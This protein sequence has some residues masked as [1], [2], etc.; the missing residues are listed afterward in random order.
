[1]AMEKF[2][3]TGSVTATLNEEDAQLLTFKLDD[4]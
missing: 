1:M 2:E 3:K 4:Q